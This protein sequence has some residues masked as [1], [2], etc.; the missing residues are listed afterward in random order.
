M[1]SRFS[2]FGLGTVAALL[3]AGCNYDVALTDQPTRNIDE[4]LI[5]NWLGGEDGKETMIVR[6]LSDTTYVVA[7]DDAI[8]RAFHTDYAGTA[9][10][11][12]ESLQSGS[13]HG[14]YVYMSWVLSADGNRLTL[15]S[16]STKLIPEETKGRA[17]LQKLIKDNL[18]NPALFNEPMVFSRKKS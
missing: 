1:N 2:L 6:Q 13:E 16:V 3:L 11:S 5:G 4:H 10:V 9:F 7:Y 12:V 17:A 18:A 15:R 8:Y 14:K